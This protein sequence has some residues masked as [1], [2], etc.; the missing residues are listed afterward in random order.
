M[1]NCQS[2]ILNCQS[3]IL[4][5]QSAILNSR[6]KIVV[7]KLVQTLHTKLF[8]IQVFKLRYIPCC[9]FNIFGL[10]DETK[11]TTVRLYSLSNKTINNSKSGS[12]IQNLLL[13]IQNL[14]LTI[15]DLYLTIDN[16]SLTIQNLQLTIYNMQLTI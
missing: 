3:A 4:N 14:L 7:F 1:L 15:Q 10:N 11:E 2:A 13:S 16:L 5:C 6:L 8:R 9:T 12:T